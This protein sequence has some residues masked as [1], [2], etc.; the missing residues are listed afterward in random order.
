[1]AGHSKWANIQHRKRNQ[2]AKRGKLFTKLIR[3]IS[4][5]A[6]SSSDPNANPNLRLAIDKA[7]DANVT[8]DAID[9]AIK[10][11]QGGDYETNLEEVRY[12]GYAPFGVAI[13]VEALTDNRN[14]TASEVRYTF[15]KFGASLGTS[16]SVAYLF[17]QKGC[18]TLAPGSDEQVVL[19]SAL[20]VGAQDV[21]VQDDGSID[22]LIA[23]DL[24]PSLKEALVKLNCTVAQTDVT[25][26]PSNYVVL[27]ADQCESIQRLIDS[28]EDLDDV[29]TV[30]TNLSK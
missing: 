15:S 2:D 23:P 1:M 16:G 22:I 4:V 11:T 9:R 5:A 7:L 21:L 19:E 25:L 26:I 30:Y 3:A 28:L 12:E 29:Q 20:T 14:R 10:R 24:L 6:K 8:K 13:L 27:T 18:L 17:S